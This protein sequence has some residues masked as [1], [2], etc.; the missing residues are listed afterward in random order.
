MMGEPM[1]SI[2]E[3]ESFLKELHAR[4]DLDADVKRLANL[5]HKYHAQIEPLSTAHSQ[6]SKVLIPLLEK[7][8]DTISVNE[9]KLTDKLAGPVQPW[10]RLRQLEVGPFRGFASPE[11]F[12]LDRRILLFYGPNGTGKTS[13]CEA[14]EHS[15]LGN[16]EEASSK[17]IEAQEY[18][19]NVY[20]KSFKQPTLLGSDAA[21]QPVRISRDLEAFQFCFIEKNRIEAFSRIASKPP[22]QRIQLIASLFG[23]EDFN[24]FVQGFNAEIDQQLRLIEAK[25][26]ELNRRKATLAADQT[27]VN[28]KDACSAEFQA[29]GETLAAEYHPGLSYKQLLDLIGSPETPSRIDEIEKIFNQPIAAQ[30]GI[31]HRALV[32]LLGEVQDDVVAVAA[33]Y[34]QLQ[35]RQSEV[36]FKGLYESLRGLEPDGF[37]VCPACS[38]PLSGEH[39]VKENPF[40]KARKG[41]AGLE[42]LAKLQERH[43]DAKRKCQRASEKLIQYVYDVAKIVVDPQETNLLQNANDLVLPM[44]AEGEWWSE[45]EKFGASGV[46]HWAALEALATHSEANDA[47]SAQAAIDRKVLTEERILLKAFERRV[48]L[49]DNQV[50]IATQKVVAAQ[51]NID[52]FD[53]ENKKLLEEV[54]LE[55]PIVALHR[56]INIAYAKFL[57]HLQAYRAKLPERL[58]Q[59]LNGIT[60]D[61]YNAFNR[62]DLD[63][64]LL[65]RLQLPSGDNTKI[66]I[67][68]KSH[69]ADL[70]DA[71]LILS[72]G[73]IRCLGLAI[74]M[75]KN[76]RQECPV[77]IFD[78]AVNAIDHD[79]RTGLRDTL[80]DN[81]LIANKQLIVTCHGE[82]FIKDIEVAIGNRRANTE[83]YSYAFL[84]HTGQR[85][86][87]VLAAET[88]NYVLDALMEFQAGKVRKS[89]ASGRRA[90]ETITSRTWT[91][92]EKRGLGEIRPKMSRRNSPLEQHDLANQLK[93]TMAKAAFVHPH[94]DDLLRGYDILLAQRN[95][96]FFNT[97]THEQD[98]ID[99]FP[100]ESVKEVI[101]NLVMLDD[102]LSGVATAPKTAPQEVPRYRTAL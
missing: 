3:F 7:E 48:L 27:L 24:D 89:I 99:D 19:K 69:P 35:T 13:F 44:L 26:L 70:H 58:T 6:R 57:Q 10:I 102:V 18:L 20:T 75:A 29:Q 95:W 41:L 14:L 30:V 53:A 39:C 55:K 28:D 100:R 5:V 17:R 60:K 71:L 91:M 90:M 42:E 79:H 87:N 43:H 86:I 47:K 82:E 88:H 94:K 62:Q 1:A 25:A 74:L 56:R 22:A 72:E 32:S 83:C 33:L 66:L 84:P 36:N 8:L 85:E 11:T 52:S 81:P 64:D 73:H 92:L 101:D 34:A 76:I 37:D 93:L 4:G 9:P 54:E 98:G 51:V 15:L 38:T 59:D 12:N 77:L 2:H 46:S 68:F 50:N 23:L 63:G 97:G 49:L 80:F 31:T 78:D 67:S 61:L 40:D 45:L 65:D 21:G 16:V 96:G